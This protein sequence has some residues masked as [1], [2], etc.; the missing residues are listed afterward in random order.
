MLKTLDTPTDRGAALRILNMG[1]DP[2]TP[3][4]KLMLTALG[5]VAEFERELILEPQ[6]EGN[7]KAKAAGMYKGRKTTVRAEAEEVLKLL[8]VDVGG[9]EVAKGR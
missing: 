4:A 6:R 1:I 8:R 2:R 5:G 7:A 3:A 9:T